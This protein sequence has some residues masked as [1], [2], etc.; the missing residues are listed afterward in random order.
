MPPAVPFLCNLSGFLLSIAVLR[1]L[2]EKRFYDKIKEI[3]ERSFAMNWMKTRRIRLLIILLCAT[4]CLSMFACGKGEAVETTAESHTA[5]TTTETAVETTVPEPTDLSLLTEEGKAQ[6]RIIRPEKGSDT[7]VNAGI[8]LNKALKKLTG[9]T[10]TLNSDFLMPKESLDDVAEVYEILIGATNRP[11]SGQAKEGLAANEYVIRA[12]EYKIVVTG[13]SDAATY[14]A[15]QAF[16]AMFEAGGSFMLAKDT[17]IKAEIESQGFLVALTNQGE[18]L[19][20]VYDISGGKLDKS[21]R[22]WSYQTPYYNIAGTKL[23]HSETHGDVALIVCGS[24]YGC[25]VSYPAGE[26]LWSTNMAANN[27]HSI[28]LMPNGVIAIAS[29]TGAEIRFFTTAE[30]ASKKIDARV[31]LED[32][33]G[34]LW[35]EQN[36]ILWAVGRTVLTAYQVVLNA[37]GTVTVT[38]DASRRATIPSDHA[39]DLAPV[40]GDSNELWITTGS[41]VYRFNKTSKTFYIDYAGCEYLNRT[42]VK[43]VGNF[44]DGSLVFLYPDGAFKSWTTKSIVLVRNQDGKM[45]KEELASETGHF[46]K[47]RVWDARYQ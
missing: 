44:E 11:E 29:S 43:G 36:Q 42:N 6:Y 26:L 32:A 16:L 37:D 24:G 1:L 34:V 31:A 22:V 33:H 45:V 2:Q 7:E 20:E 46:Y 23:R 38:E 18:S 47:A 13:G 17:D 28:E 8:E 10:F 41:S 39:H 14:Q 5:A 15:M 9:A 35:D 25:M 12:T 4:L 27:P 3:S 19:L 40:Y 21:T 30:K